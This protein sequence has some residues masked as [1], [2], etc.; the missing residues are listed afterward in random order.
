[1]L[2][3][4]TFEGPSVVFIQE[5]S[6]A[7]LN[8]GYFYHIVITS[9]LNFIQVTIR[10]TVSSQQ[11]KVQFMLYI[12]TYF[13]SS[14]CGVDYRKQVVVSFTHFFVYLFVQ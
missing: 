13:G 7:F 2:L 4:C 6:V 14:K 12:D 1:M 11:T 9:I 8:G 3:Y 5:L 10:K